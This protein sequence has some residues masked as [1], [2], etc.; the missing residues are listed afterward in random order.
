MG[1]HRTIL[2]TSLM[3]ENFHICWECM[4]AGSGHPW[5][6]TP[7]GIRQVAAGEGNGG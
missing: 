4:C 7:G 5:R 2:A 6:G 3:F 1:G